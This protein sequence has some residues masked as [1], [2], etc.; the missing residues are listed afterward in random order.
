MKKK[1]TK[2]LLMAAAFLTLAVAH[3]Q[4]RVN[5]WIYETFAG[6]DS[7]ISKAAAE[8]M[9]QNPDIEINLIPTAGTSSAYRDPF[10]VAAQGGGGP[11]VLM[12]DIAWSPEFAAMGI[13]KDLSERMAGKEDEFFPGPLDTLRYEGGIYGVPFYTNALGMFYNKT[14]FEEA[15][16]PLPDDDWTW[17]DF[18]TAV[19][20][21]SDGEMYGFGLEGAWG[22]TFEWYPWFWQAG[23]QLLSD[24]GTTPTFNSEAGLEATRFFLDIVTNPRYVPEAAKT[25]KGWAELAAAFSNKVIA[26]YEVGDWGIAMVDGMNP[27]FE[28]GVA[29]LP[30]N[31]QRA[32]LVGGANWVVN[33]NTKVEDAAWR[34]LEY[35]TGPAVFPLMDGYNRVA[36]RRGAAE[37][38]EIVKSDP[39]MQV[40]TASLEFA[41]ARPTVPLWT[42]VDYDCLQPAFVRV[43][44]EGA[45]V[46]TEMANAEMCALD[47][48]R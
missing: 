6:N 20:T 36:A 12:A 25:W 37:A 45:D 1:S 17:Y 42:T 9:A 19:D 28:W 11:D 30:A 40:L 39:R 15:G 29:P 38:Q 18:R 27:P 14:A 3:A 24:D 33:A 32:S 43:I 47:V 16:L 5:V 13:V 22:G 21:L 7:P 4:T 31:G 48:L 2:L 10:M 46:T 41:K 26:M 44:L 34:W 35:I 8:F 23:G